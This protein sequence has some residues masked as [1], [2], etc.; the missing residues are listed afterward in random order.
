V[1]FKII[2]GDTKFGEL[3]FKRG[4]GLDPAITL[5]PSRGFKCVP[6]C[7]CNHL[8][9]HPWFTL[10]LNIHCVWVRLH[11]LCIFKY[12]LYVGTF[13][14]AEYIQIFIVWGGVCTCWVY[15]NIHCAWVRLQL[16]CIFKYLLYVG[17][18][19]FAVYI[20]IF[21]VGGYV[22]YSYRLICMSTSYLFIC[23]KRFLSLDI[24]WII[25]WFASR[26]I[27][28][29]FF[30]CSMFLLWSLVVLVLYLFLLFI[31]LFFCASSVR[32]LSFSNV[33]VNFSLTSSS[34]CCFV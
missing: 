28:H 11:L 29:L 3:K 14:F 24:H 27:N 2:Y 31:L 32:N 18:F 1:E 6:Q 23:F 34:S 25:H 4:G 26:Y 17:T 5:L 21:I 33:L 13:T 10:A 8:S 20:Q 9:S 30:P 16:L 19:T 7:H 12:S 15:S 22:L